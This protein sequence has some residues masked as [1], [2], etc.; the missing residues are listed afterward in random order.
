[1]A[2][3]R[4]LLTQIALAAAQSTVEAVNNGELQKEDMDFLL[5]EGDGTGASAKRETIAVWNDSEIHSIAQKKQEEFREHIEECAKELA[6]SG[7]RRVENIRGELAQFLLG[8]VRRSADE[9]SAQSVGGMVE[10]LLHEILGGAIEWTGRIWVSGIVAAENAIQVREGIALRR[11]EPKDFTRRVHAGL[12]GVPHTPLHSPDAILEC[13]FLAP[14]PPDRRQLI[15]ALSLYR[16]APVKEYLHHWTNNSVIRSNEDLSYELFKPSAP[17]L[18]SPELSTADGNK[19]IVFVKSVAEKL[20]L[21]PVGY[22]W[23]GLKFYFSALHTAS[24]VEE[25]LSLAVASLEASLLSGEKT[26]IKHRLSLRTASLLRFVGLNPSR[27]FNETRTAYDLRSTYAHGGEFKAIHLEQV[28][29]LCPRILDYAR[30]AVVKLLEFTD[31]AE[32]KKLLSQLD[33]ALVDDKERQVLE[34]SLKGGSWDYAIA[35]EEEVTAS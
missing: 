18:P 34:S 3:V 23:T 15:N 6:E 25:R 28:R 9:Q 11:P 10:R 2:D 4:D 8:I 12:Y 35:T 33:L 24:D 30:L 32:R 31:K 14:E 5:W 7:G 1:M 13:S 26:E 27:V 21:K 16:A 19:L 29:E 17:G 20:P 22:P